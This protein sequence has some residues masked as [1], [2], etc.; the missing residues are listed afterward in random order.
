M[1]TADASAVATMETLHS[2]KAPF[3][4]KEVTSAGAKIG[5]IEGY[6]A[7]W[8]P[9]T[10]GVFGVPDQFVPGAFRASLEDHVS[11]NNRQVR[12]KDMHGR[13]IGGFPIETVV[14]DEVGLKGVGRVNL[15][16]QLGAE[17]WALIKQGVISDL[18]V[19]FIALEDKIVNGVRK[20][21]KAQLMEA[22]IVD[23]PANRGAQIL[24]FHN[25]QPFYDLPIADHE[26]PWDPIGALNRVQE[27]TRVQ[28]DPT[29]EWK[30]CF[31]QASHGTLM[32]S[33]VDVV[34]GR[35]V[36]IPKAVQ[37]LADS[38]LDREFEG[39]AAVVRHLERYFAKMGMDSPFPAEERQFVGVDEVK[40]LLEDGK[41][42]AETLRRGVAF[43]KGAAK[44][45]ANRL[46]I[47]ASK[48]EPIVQETKSSYDREDV[49]RILAEIREAKTLIR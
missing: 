14:E 37:E 38:M 26:H 7:T 34:D 6:L 31:V 45:A 25:A 32:H 16:T 35:I 42:L 49:S 23:E 8:E 12:L 15:E 43:S 1:S 29:A 39:K 22:S 19:G 3:E 48:E 27:F 36:A 44:L 20:I 10:G 18:S 28:T 9:D 41:D 33:I 2:C 4:V 47:D 30:K 11:R 17:A 21:F 13:V 46:T 40:A 24:E 5:T